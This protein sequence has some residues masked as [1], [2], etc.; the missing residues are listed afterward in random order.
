MQEFDLAADNNQSHRF[1]PRPAA[2]APEG[3]RRFVLVSVLAAMAGMLV[4][5]FVHPFGDPRAETGNGRGLDLLAANM[6]ASARDVLITKCADCHSNDTHYPLY[7]GIAPGSWLM[8]WD[9]VEGRRH[10]DLSR[11]DELTPDAR[12]SLAAQIM[13]EVKSG[14]MPPLQYLAL[15]WGARPT[16]ADLQALV[17]LANTNWNNINETNSGGVNAVGDPNPSGPGDVARGKLAFEKR[18]ASCHSMTKNQQGPQLAGLMGRRA[19]SV[20]R[21]A[22]SSALKKSGLTWTEGTLEK[23]LA[24]PDTL[25]PDT[26]MEYRVRSAEER[27]D[28]IAYLSR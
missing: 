28:L 7:A 25:V 16:A 23:W 4:L 21:F 17:S 10:M 19:A 8:E 20:P 9:I 15:H 18:C 12:E 11:W 3:R 22:Y 24:D 2:E 5:G 26:T 6:P 1:E 14:K 13:L 27:L